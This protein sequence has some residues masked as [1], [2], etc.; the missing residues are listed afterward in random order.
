MYKKRPKFWRASR[1]NSV[2]SSRLF[3]HLCIDS[4]LVSSNSIKSDYK[5]KGFNPHTELVEF[6]VKRQGCELVRFTQ[7]HARTVDY[8]FYLYSTIILKAQT[9]TICK[10]NHGYI[11]RGHFYFTFNIACLM[12]SD[13]IK[14]LQ[15]QT[16][17]RHHTPPERII[18]PY[19]LCMHHICSL[20]LYTAIDCCYKK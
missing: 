9:T 2:I 17:R 20:S 10:L 16:N 15:L 12:V 11:M 7:Q 5:E 3:S 8:T 14:I 13:Y 19:V 18:A 6:L 4:S 1:D